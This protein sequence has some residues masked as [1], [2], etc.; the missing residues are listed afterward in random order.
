MVVEFVFVEVKV[1]RIT[2]NNTVCWNILNNMTE[3]AIIALSPIQTPDIIFTLSGIHMS[4]PM[5]TSCTLCHR[6]A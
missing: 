1:C 2:L 6:M 3:H 5:I 4:F